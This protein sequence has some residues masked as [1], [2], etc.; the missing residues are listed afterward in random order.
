MILQGLDFSQADLRKC[1]FRHAV[2][3]ACSLREANVAGAR[4]EG[5]DLLGPTSA[6]YASMTRHYSGAIISW[7][8]AGQLL[9]ELGLKVCRRQSRILE[10]PN[11]LEPHRLMPWLA[12]CCPSSPCP[13]NQSPDGTP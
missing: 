4:F 9:A 3:Q 8:Q 2:F 5:A 1:D 6:A 7:Q 10:I 12:V 11:K 13:L